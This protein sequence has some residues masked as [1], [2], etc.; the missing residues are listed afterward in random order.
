MPGSCLVEI[1]LK[2][3]SRQEK[4]ETDG[5]GTLRVWVNAPPV[6]GRAN[7]AL[8]EL[9]SETLHVPKSYVSIKRGLGSKSK[10]VEVIGL[11]QE[12]IVKKVSNNNK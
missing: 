10:V 8:I 3:N 2:P 11:T 6:E 12:E 4:V 1:R 7:A 9:L 5:N